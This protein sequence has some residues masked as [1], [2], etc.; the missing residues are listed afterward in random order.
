MSDAIP[1]IR[2][3]QRFG[4]GGLPAGSAVRAD[5]VRGPMFRKR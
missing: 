3:R 4:G 1:R 5:D 2:A